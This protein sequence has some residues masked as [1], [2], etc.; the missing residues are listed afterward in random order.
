MLDSNQTYLLNNSYTKRYLIFAVL[1]KKV[2][3]P[4]KSVDKT[5][6]C[7]HYECFRAVH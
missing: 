1:A 4:L 5:L 3:L 2:V 7:D 6:V